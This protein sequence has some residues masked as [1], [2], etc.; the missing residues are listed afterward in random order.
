[1]SMSIK[2][3]NESELKLRMAQIYKEEKIKELKSKWEK[4]TKEEKIFVLEFY[5]A[6]HPDSKLLSESRWYNWIG[7]I[8]GL[9]PG[10]EL[11][12][13]VNGVSY[14]RQGEKFFSLLSFLA[15]IPAMG[16]ITNPIKL[17]SRGGSAVLTALRGAVALGD[18]GKI[19]GIASKSGVIGK[20]VGA[21]GTWGSKLLG[22]LARIGERIPFVRTIIKGM[23]GIVDMFTSAKAKM[24]GALG[25]ST[26]LVPDLDGAKPIKVNIGA[27]NSGQGGQNDQFSNMVSSMFGK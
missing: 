26:S 3:L 22:V 7:D 10:L 14:W 23:R 16:F 21:V 20:F 13:V 27:P 4:F 24:G 25:K 1:M 12:N 15:G 2:V 17:L 8:V 9:I 18:S 5:K 11:V 6:L 19:A